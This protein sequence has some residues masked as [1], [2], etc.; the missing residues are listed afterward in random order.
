[1][2]GSVQFLNFS[3][4]GSKTKHASYLGAMGVNAGVAEM[5]LAWESLHFMHFMLKSVHYLVNHA[6]NKFSTVVAKPWHAEWR[7]IEVV[8]DSSFHTYVAH[9]FIVIQP[10][11][12]TKLAS[13]FFQNQ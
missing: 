12:Q 5:I 6:P 1:M 13:H 2:A 3:K 11:K 8:L 4:Y 7:C 10:E 9:I